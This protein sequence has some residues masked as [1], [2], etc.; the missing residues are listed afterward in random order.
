MKLIKLIS[1]C[2]INWLT[3]ERDPSAFPICDFDR[4]RYELRP[5]DVLLIEGR[6]RVSEVIKI[7]TQSSWSH[8]AL[9]IG[10]IHDIED[11]DI[12]QY[13]MKFF[14][15]PPD[16]Q[17][18]VEGVMGKGTIISSL[19][20]YK[21]DH[22]RICRPRG[23]S[24][25]DAQQIINYSIEKLGTDYDVRQI[26]DLA[27][28]LFPWT[29]MPRKWRS[30]LFSKSAGNSTR[31]V[32]STMLAS[33]FEV[34]DFPILPYVKKHETKG[35]ELIPRN[36]KLFTPRDFDYS[37]YFEII[38][39]PF[40]EFDSHAMYRKLPWNREGLV[41]NDN[42][43]ITSHPKANS[44]WVKPN[45]D[46]H[47]NSKTMK[48]SMWSRPSAKIILNANKNSEEENNNHNEGNDVQNK[49]NK[50]NKDHGEE[51]KS[52]RE[53]NSN[54]K[55]SNKSNK[56]N[57]S[58]N[59]SNGRS[60]HELNDGSN[61][62]N[63][64]VNCENGDVNCE[65]GDSNYKNGGANYESHN[66][67]RQNSKINQNTANND[68]NNRKDASKNTGN[69]QHARI[70]QNDNNKVM[71]NNN[72]QTTQ[73]YNANANA[74]HNHDA[75]LEQNNKNK[76]N[77]GVEQNGENTSTTRKILSGKK[78]FAFFRGKGNQHD[79]P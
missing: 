33:A 12:R 58:N 10:R 74:G 64:D 7:I 76:Q 20:A 2:F 75:G 50:K 8:S 52:H 68:L 77:N 14:D 73:R 65:N 34:V 29:I 43:D 5:C 67:P 17:L 70:K 48:K 3:L 45:Y 63:D 79:N 1:Q 40:I 31:T 19:T 32:C 57:K 27:R 69:E 37:P 62:K 61:Y 25:N 39:Y 53:E 47:K 30:R 13:A 23:L 18:L 55:K 72:D 11:A 26:L 51:N 49:H 56:F 71:Q 15:G 44:E 4:I 38:K 22:I 16:T 59:G 24:P 54:N 28:F 9:Y 42:E 21:K 41:S 36:T 6:S 35:I 66:D 60:N 78:L 46:V